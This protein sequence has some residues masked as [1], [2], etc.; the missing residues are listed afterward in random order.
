MYVKHGSYKFFE[1]VFN[2]SVLDLISFFLRGSFIL[3]FDRKTSLFH[4]VTQAHMVII[5]IIEEPNTLL[6]SLMD[7]PKGELS[8]YRVRK[9]I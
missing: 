9:C 1:E 6:M 3:S 8:L 2:I 4:P 5:L 7:A